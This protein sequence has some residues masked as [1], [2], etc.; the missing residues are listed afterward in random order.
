MQFHTATLIVALSAVLLSM[1]PNTQAAPRKEVSKS[2]ATAPPKS[3]TPCTIGG[4]PCPNGVFCIPLEETYG[5]CPVVETP[6]NAL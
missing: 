5:Y 6:E 1:A 2:A 4:E 3:T